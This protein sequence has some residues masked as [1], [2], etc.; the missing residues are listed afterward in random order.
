MNS[1]LLCVVSKSNEFVLKFLVCWCVEFSLRKLFRKWCISWDCFVIKKIYYHGDFY[2]IF[3]LLLYSYWTCV[4][5]DSLY[6]LIMFWLCSFFMVFVCRLFLTIARVLVVWS[7]FDS[8][9]NFL[10][11]LF[12]CLILDEDMCSY[13]LLDFL[14]I[15]M[16]SIKLSSPYLRLVRGV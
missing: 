3:P 16:S 8:E 1:V 12:T 10:S 2:F 6:I 15:L 13:L 11:T 9:S 5:N 7:M 4:G 14:S